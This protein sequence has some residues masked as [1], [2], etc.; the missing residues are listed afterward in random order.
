M[1]LGNS[2]TKNTK[3]RN[4]TSELAINRLMLLF[5]AA[6]FATLGMVYLNNIDIHTEAHFVEYVLPTCTIVTGVLLLAALAFFIYK[7][8]RRQDDSKKVFSSG[9]LLFIAA[10]LFGFFA[11]FKLIKSTPNALTVMIGAV[12]VV[13]AICFIYYLYNRDFFNYAVMTAV[14]AVLMYLGKEPFDFVGDTLGSVAKLLAI[15]MPIAVIVLLVLNKAGKLN[16]MNP[17]YK[18]Y[19]FF[20]GAGIML[21]TMLVSLFAPALFIYLFMAFLAVFLIITIA[22]TVRM[23]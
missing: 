18:Y 13:T 22:Y 16:F 7:R 6:I 23:I 2:K 5:C 9:V 19:P 21:G 17:G 3:K 4:Q 1:I 12:V 8:V 10:C 20:T 11:S 15:L 14:G